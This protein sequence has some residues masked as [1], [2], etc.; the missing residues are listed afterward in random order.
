[1]RQRL[2][3]QRQFALTDK[4]GQRL[5]PARRQVDQLTPSLLKESFAS[6]TVDTY[7]QKIVTA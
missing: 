1:M 2:H 6:G 7:Q 3:A 5:A 4:L